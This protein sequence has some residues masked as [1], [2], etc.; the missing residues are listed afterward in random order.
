MGVL[1][2]SDGQ[3]YMR[4]EAGGLIW[5]LMKKARQLVVLMGPVM[6]Q[7]MNYFKKIWNV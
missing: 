6:T 5:G 2:D 3:W 4:E 7:N 1:R